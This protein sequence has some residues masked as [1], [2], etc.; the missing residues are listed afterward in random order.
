M[1]V[2]PDIAVN[3][4]QRYIAIVE[5]DFW[6][7]K[8]EKIAKISEENLVFPSFSTFFLFYFKL[9]FHL[10]KRPKNWLYISPPFLISPFFKF[11][12]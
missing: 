9:H 5:N 1:S 2:N 10:M 8:D 6:I 7:P 4:S 12:R 3:N 11:T